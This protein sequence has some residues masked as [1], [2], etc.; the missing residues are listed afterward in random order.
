MITY[1]LFMYVIDYKKK[2]G[3][4]MATIHEVARHAGVSVATVSRVINNNAK[5]TEQTKDRVDKAIDA[6]RYEPSALGRNLRNLET[7]LLL[8]MLPSISNPFYSE[9]INGIEDTAIDKGYHILLCETD[10]NPKRETIYFNMVRN[11]L[12]DGIISMDPTVNKDR[13]TELATNYPIVQC[14]EYDEEGAIPYVTID[15]ELAAYQAV[16][17]L[18][19]LGRKNIA[20]I[21]SDETFLYARERRRGY[22]KAL[23]EFGL[24]VRQEW[25]YHTASL[26]FESG[27]QAVRMLFRQDEKPNA[28]FAVSDIFAIGALKEINAKGLSVPQDIAVIGFDKI[29]FSNMT[30]PT[31]TTVAQPRYRMGTIAAGMIINKILGNKVESIMLDHELTIREST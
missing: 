12:A 28:I 2:A 25:I 6:L 10:S 13:L 23:Q 20:L 24:P 11:H 3:V 4:P 1:I 29:G 15:N 26:E 17:H 30:H 31:L 7:K 19:K 22:E 21:N 16:R 18:V 8:V 27:Q 9:I 14:S 5:V